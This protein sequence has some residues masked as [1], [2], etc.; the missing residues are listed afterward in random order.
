MTQTDKKR[1]FIVDVAYIVLL[2]LMLVLFLEYAFYP[3]L[4]IFIALLVALVLQRP[5]KFLNRN[6][7]IPK[8]IIAV[9]LVFAL[10]ALIGFAVYI[11]GEKVV[12]EAISFVKFIQTF[13]TDYDW[14][15]R[16]VHS[17][18]N[19]LPGFIQ[20]NIIDSVD[21]VLAN[22]KIAM[23]NDAAAGDYTISLSSIDFSFLTDKLAGGISTGVSG[24]IATAKHVPSVLVA[25]IIG[26]ILCIFM[27]I[28]YDDVI[29]IIERLLSEEN[30]LKF[31]ATRRVMKHSV[32]SLAKAYAIICTLTF[33]ELTIGLTV[34]KTLGIFNGNYLVIIA[35]ITA[36][37]DIL[38]VM[39]IGTVMWPWMALSLVSGDTKMLIGLFV[40]YAIITVIRHILEPKLISDT[41]E[42]PV[43]LT[44]SIMYIGLK[45]FGVLGMFAFILVLYCVVALNKEGVIHLTRQ[46]NEAPSEEIAEEVVEEIAEKVE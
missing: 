22:L 27:T 33:A 24:V 41:M 31:D 40:I 2:V 20:E 36:I 19:A 23:E 44:L 13:V 1:K 4:P 26:I 45:F 5:M 43:A 25:I 11:I 21:E 15:D 34:L 14:I 28:E 42:L 9:V 38:P 46:P 18:V 7:K 35:L 39:G 29:D 17:I 30:A 10:L 32:G 12:D 6:L 37:L 16:Q 3:L 8:A